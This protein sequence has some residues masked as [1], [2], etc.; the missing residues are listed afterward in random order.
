M[1]KWAQTKQFSNNMVS[2][3]MGQVA[4]SGATFAGSGG[5]GMG[6]GGGEARSVQ[7]TG[8]SAMPQSTRAMDGGGSWGT[9]DYQQGAD[10]APTKYNLYR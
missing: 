4:Q 7:P 5:G 1:A 9:V 2:S 3:G 10:I 8:A 6:G